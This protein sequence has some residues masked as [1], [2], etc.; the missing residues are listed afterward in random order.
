MWAP[1]DRLHKERA[2]M[3]RKEDRTDT[4]KPVIVVGIFLGLHILFA[5]WQPVPVWGADFLRFHD[6]VFRAIFVLL[7]VALL[8]LAA[9]RRLGRW[10]S[11]VARLF[12]SGSTPWK[13]V[14][15]WVLLL[16]GGLLVFWG[17]RSAV[18]LLG[19][20]I[21]LMRELEDFWSEIPRTDRAPLT[22]W[23]VRGLHR[24][25]G[26]FAWT[27]AET[28][29]R[30]FSCL[31]GILF[32]VVVRYT[33]R[34]LGKDALERFLIFA[35]LLGA[36]YMQLFF[37]YVENYAFLFPFM[38]L[39]LLLGIRALEGRLAIWWPAALLG[40]L[41]ALHIT[42]MTLAPS[43]LALAILKGRAEGVSGTTGP[44]RLTV[45]AAFAILLST[46]VFFGAL[47][48]IQFDLIAYLQKRQGFYILNLFAEPGPK[49]HYRL[50]SIG[51]WVDFVN[52]YYLVAPASLMV[53]LLCRRTRWLRG[54]DRQFVM[55]AALFPILFTVVANPELGAFRD[56][57]VFAFA[58]LP[59]TLWAALTIVRELRDRL[60]SADTAGLICTAAVLHTVFWIGI[61]ADELSAEARFSSHLNGGYLS[62][63]ARSHGWETLAV[64]HRDHGRSV[65]AIRAYERVVDADP[66]FA[67][68]Y[69]NLGNL[70]YDLKQYDRAAA[71]FQKVIALK[72]DFAEAHYNFGNLYYDTGQ[73]DLAILQFEKVIALKKDFAEA[74]FQMGNALYG[75]REYDRAV[76][77]FEEAIALKP[78]FVAAYYNVGDLY[79][80]TGQFDAAVGAY[81]KAIALNPGNARAHSNLGNAYHGLRDYQQ[82]ISAYEQA[83]ELDPGYAEG[84]YNLGVVYH[85][86]GDVE[87]TRRCFRKVLE[88]APEHPQ[89]PALRSWLALSPG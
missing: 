58:A 60:V 8:L 80:R 82:A 89:A 3:R 5:Y 30:L 77:H 66:D 40:V 10:T 15:S 23:I 75:L 85:T 18:H 76:E 67:G 59:M 46:V 24:A 28:T 2:M 47:L 1:A 20:G 13:S 34:L 71:Y 81:R 45:R 17:M 84:F 29:Y 35:L 78:Q 7:S 22:F 53:L 11:G 51:K 14:L 62:A 43:L 68:G 16:L 26:A 37:A 65:P 21:M 72:P 61:N 12:Y 25:A 33:A 57:D 63:H 70:H 41:M 36:G 52:Q 4:N 42:M 32:L 9:R 49:Q 54:P 27:S 88:L 19:D 55:V 56:W 69:Y 83:V 44:G 73:Y 79:Y 39:Y 6:S 50:F 38:L 48:L 87:R 64:Y 74:H 86:L 31:S